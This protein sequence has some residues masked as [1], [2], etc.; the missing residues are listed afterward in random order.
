MTDDE[1]PHF[2][3]PPDPAALA[4]AVDQLTTQFR[5]VAE[6]LKALTSAYERDGK[7]RRRVTTALVVV[8]LAGFIVAGVAISTALRLQEQVDA[9]KVEACLR[10]NVL[11][12][13]IY[14]EVDAVLDTIA[15][16]AA[17]EGRKVLATAKESVRE[18]IPLR[19]CG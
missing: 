5:D 9:D 4:H 17:T 10:G 19:D 15:P 11:R 16:A 18:Q 2:E 3:I 12:L 6:G 14:S 13:D 1:S 8:T 7:F